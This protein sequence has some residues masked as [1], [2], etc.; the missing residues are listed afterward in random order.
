MKIVVCVKHVAV[1]GDEIRF[2]TDERDVDEDYYDR[3]L[4]EWDAC[5]AEEA[6]RIR[7]RLG[8]EGE[9]LVVTVGG[10]SADVAL[11]RCLAMG[12][13]RAVRISFDQTVHDPIAIGHALSEAIV[14]EQPD[15]VLVGV[16]SSDS[17][18]GSTGTA[19]AQFLDLPR[20][21]VVKKVEYDHATR[22]ATCHRELEGGLVDV[23]EVDTPAV[24]AIQTGIN[25]PRYPTFRAIKD[26]ER[27]EISLVSAAGGAVSGYHVRRMFVPPKPEGAEM[28]DGGPA[29]VARRIAEIVKE[30]L[31]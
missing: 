26:A 18:Q 17:V 12:A 20:V 25:E 19:L 31:A 21:A 27:K 22:R 5:A 28:L 7:E 30:R 8:G 9:V 4:N 2:T 29:D 10:P 1:L 11:Q 6:L 15:L 24:L 23:V 3:T 13:D 16:Q 14:P